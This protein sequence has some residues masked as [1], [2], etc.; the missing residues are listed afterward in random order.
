[1]HRLRPIFAMVLLLLAGISSAAPAPPP[2]AL[3]NALSRG[4]NIAI[5]F[6]H[7]DQPGIDP[8]LWY[9][10]SADWRLISALGFKHVR[11]QFDPAFFRDPALDGALHQ[12]HMRLLQRELSNAWAAGLVVVLAAEPMGPE[13]SR[14]VK[15]DVGIAE[16][17][18]FWQ[19]FAGALKSQQP[20]RLVFEALNEPTDTDAPRNREL[21]QKL[22]EAIRRAAPRHTIVV[23]GHAYS[24][25][26]ELLAFEPL[27]M[28]NL[29]YSLHFYE[30]QN[31]TH[32]GATWSWPMFTKF[33]GLPYPS[34]SEAVA[35]ILDTLE[36]QARPHVKF[37]GESRWD[38]ARIAARL[39]LARDWAK[40]NGVP[41]WCS[42]FGVARL[43]AP[44]DSRSRWLADVRIALEARGLP[45]T[46]FD[47]AG[48]F[49]LV[50]G[51]AGARQLDVADTQALGLL[52]SRR[53]PME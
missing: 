21:M 42:E 46:L 2:T 19:Q 53:A 7:R 10:D 26:D 20:D 36:E 34:S 4:V 3:M 47:Y 52:P 5:W 15:D 33:K 24:G 6:T 44:A 37:Y 1:M 12:E 38:A 41:I 22:A 23:E 45:W 16:L 31:Y 25:I 43:G 13:K 18:A 17:A 28:P 27:A 49:G 11:V 35:P 14:L 9:P 32:Q 40:A 48:P 51:Q 50:N 30:P 29:I 39:D 8:A